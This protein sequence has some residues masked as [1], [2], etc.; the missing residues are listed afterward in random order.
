MNLSRTVYRYKSK[1]DDSQ[2][3]D[4]V[5]A[6]ALKRPTDGQDMIYYRIRNEGIKWNYKRIRRVYMKLNL[7]KR[8]KTRKRLPARIKEPL[9]C[10]EE[11]NHGWSMDFMHDALSNGR[12]FR[13]LN[14]I[15]DYNREVLAIG[16]HLSIGAKLVTDVL[17]DVIRERGK[18][19]IIRV[20][21]GP[22]FISSTLGDWCCQR[23]IKLQFIQPGKPTQNGYVERFNR[24]YRRE[25]L[26]AY[27]FD[28]L[29][30]VRILTEE[31]IEEYN[32]QRP[33]ESLG[34][35]PP[36]V[37]RKQ[38]SNFKCREASLPAFKDHLLTNN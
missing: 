34:G 20:D 28:S 8:N 7:N 24:T 5:L 12:K 29:D 37:Y 2:V 17:S 23:D 18:P 33:H 11:P 16:A 9:F 35:I 13:T 38:N 26:D 32:N 25:I 31:W 3:E 30:Q 22:E 19:Q 36:A 10:P 1:R 14:V 6:L 15:D 4:K 21:N 27:L